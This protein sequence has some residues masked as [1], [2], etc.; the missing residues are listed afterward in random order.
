M[1]PGVLL[2]V[3]VNPAMKP[4]KAVFFRCAR[5]VERAGAA[6][7]MRWAVWLQLQH[8]LMPGVLLTGAPPPAAR[9]RALRVPARVRAAARERARASV[10]GEL[11]RLNINSLQTIWLGGT[12]LDGVADRSR[13]AP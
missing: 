8:L 3:L 9:P 10:D 4:A 1:L 2:Q 12:E 11:L 7:C 5:W 13:P 6:R